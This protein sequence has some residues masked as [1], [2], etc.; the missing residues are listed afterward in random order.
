MANLL[1]VLAEDLAQ[2]PQFD[3]AEAEKA[4]RALAANKGVKAGLLINASRVALTGQA[5]APSLFAVMELL[6]QEKTVARLRAARSQ[7]PTQ[8]G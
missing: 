7:L 6:G 1:T 8:A 4:L 3:A 2:L 5:V